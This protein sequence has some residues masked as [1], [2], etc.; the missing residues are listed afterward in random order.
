VDSTGASRLRVIAGSVELRRDDA[1]TI[2]PMGLAAEVDVGGRP[3]TPYPFDVSEAV[4]AAL[5]R[6]D[7]GDARPGDLDTVLSALHTPDHHPTFRRRSAITLWYVLQRVP[8]TDRALVYERLTAL[9][10]AP[11]GITREGMLQLDR[12]MLERWRTDL[13]PSWSD[14]APTWIGRLGR[15]L[16]EW[17]LR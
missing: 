17:A 8:P 7:A 16:V 15:R 13:H 11:E 2:V 3:G 9:Y 1:V 4:R 6:I 14:E 10:P 12:L 5:H